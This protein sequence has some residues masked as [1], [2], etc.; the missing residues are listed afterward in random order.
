VQQGV[1]VALGLPQRQV[2]FEE[3]AGSDGT[4][5]PR[6]R[7]QSA[8]AADADGPAPSAWPRWAERMSRDPRGGWRR[9][10]GEPDLAADLL[11]SWICQ[12]LSPVAHL[13]PPAISGPA[14]VSHRGVALRDQAARPGCLPDCR[15]PDRRRAAG[16]TPQARTR[17][18][19]R[20]LAAVDRARSRPARRGGGAA[21]GGLCP[22]GGRAEE[23]E[24]L[25]QGHSIPARCPEKWLRERTFSWAARDVSVRELF[26]D[27]DLVESGPGPPAARSAGGL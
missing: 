7:R 6:W 20:G 3:A 5:Q 18:A 13:L 16:A 12:I 23:R 4:P 8:G 26:W 15:G 1:A 25:P 27:P 9:R 17:H 10:L 14:G 22:G 11:R 19:R 21:R 2:P 24:L